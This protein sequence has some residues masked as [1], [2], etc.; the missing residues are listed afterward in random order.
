MRY[1]KFDIATIDE[2]IREWDSTL[3]DVKQPLSKVTVSLDDWVV[4]QENTPF[5][6]ASIKGR[7]NDQGFY[8]LC[9]KL[10]APT[11]WMRGSCP[12][13]LKVTVFNRLMRDHQ[14]NSLL[15]FRKDVGS[16]LCR[17]VL[18]DRYM[19]F[20]N[21]DTWEAVKSG[22]L[23]SRLSELQ[24]KIWKPII[25]DKMSFYVLFDGVVA[26][27]DK[28]I[29]SYDGGGAGGLKPAIYVRN[30]E[31]GTGSISLK[32]GL[33][34][35]YCANGV[36]F[37]FNKRTSVRVVHLGYRKRFVAAEI[38]MAIGETAELA[39][40]GI[41]KYI[42]ATEEYISG[43]IDEVVGNWSKKYKMSDDT[44]ALWK[45][46]VLR[47]RTWADFVMAT[48]DFAGGQENR[49][50]QEMFEELSGELLFANHSQYVE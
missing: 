2:K 37:G 39:G 11:R 22:I 10:D 23:T 12:E 31:D 4:T 40:V 18:S 50:D 9:Q 36:I 28:S 5:G 20:N 21:L 45:G 24:P 30:A 41:D 32:A 17:A 6:V 25:D 38:K 34:R 44:T 16:Y 42:E 15:R 13:D 49:N 48:S 29:Q 7:L 47:S 43:G 33:Y 35:S 19:I 46:S 3:V 27:P 8:S 14:T 1:T 26:D